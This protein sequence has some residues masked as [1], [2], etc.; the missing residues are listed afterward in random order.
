MAVQTPVTNAGTEEERSRAFSAAI[1]NAMRLDPDTIMIGEVRDR[2]SAQ[3][4]L[5]AAMTGHQVWT[6]VHANGAIAVVDR[7]VDLGLPL[8][9]VADHG[10]TT[11]LISQRL[12]KVLCP[13]CKLPLLSHEG[14]LS[15]DLMRRVKRVARA[16]LDNVHIVGPGCEYCRGHGTIG[17]TVVAEIVL[18]DAQFFEYVRTG[19][20]VRAA[21]YWLE[22]LHGRTLLDHAIEKVSTGQVDPRM[23]EKIVGHLHRGAGSPDRRLSIVEAAHAG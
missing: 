4:A 3:N 12:M 21:Q 11:G 2:A 6:T 13:V 9:M 19:Q 20:K 5:R 18:P 15:D 14:A 16:A 8:E 10:V 17:R 1:A 22:D 23:A 7:L